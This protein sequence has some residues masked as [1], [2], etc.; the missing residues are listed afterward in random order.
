[1]L[2]GVDGN[3]A[4]I[5]NRVGTGQYAYYLL[6]HWQKIASPKQAFRIYLSSPV[7]PWLPKE[8]SYFTYTVFGPKKFW[9][10]IALPIN[11]LLERNKPEVF[12]SPAHYAPRF[13]SVKS[14]VTIHD[15]AYLTHPKEFKKKDQQ[16]LSSW[17]KYSV[18]Q[19]Q[20][21]I[22]VSENT[23][24]DLINFYQLPEKKI[25][26]VYNGFDSNRFHPSLAKLTSQKTKEKYKIKG[27]YLA[28]LGTLQPRKNLESL[29]RALPEIVNQNP[30]IKL[31]VIG[32]KGWLYSTI[33]SL[34]QTLCLQEKVIFTDFV[35]DEEVP[36][37]VAGAR[38]FILPSL[39]EG[40]G[41]TVLEAMA[42]G[43]PVVVSRV[44]S[45]PEV[46]GE[47][48]LYLDNPKNYSQIAK[49]IN[50]IL[51]DERLAKNL[52]KDGLLQSKKFSWEKCAQETLEVIQRT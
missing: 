32:K 14:V 28:Y 26:V 37:L 33:F 3:E 27:D 44:S 5:L 29:I 17:T 12:F 8:N 25:S 9:T 2:I 34:V 52:I 31:V 13:S 1:M 35:P 51:S 21:I 48:G 19:A 49:Q 45:L 24:N 22:A 15:L 11:L 50:K 40:F 38:V 6:K 23:K 43:V 10:Q 47:A 41:L 16:Q 7:N 36:F 20:K 18:D 4:N 30:E 46:V 42:C 39:Y